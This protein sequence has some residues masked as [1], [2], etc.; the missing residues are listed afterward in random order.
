MLLIA[1]VSTIVDLGCTSDEDQETTLTRQCS[2]LRAHVVDLRLETA[3]GVNVERHRQAMLDALGER[4]IENC[5]DLPREE[6]QCALAAPDSRSILECS[7]PSVSS[8]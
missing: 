5:R 8:R 1:L 4:F 6:I 2:A 7:S 3:T